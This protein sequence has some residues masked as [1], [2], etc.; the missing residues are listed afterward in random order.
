MAKSIDVT[1]EKRRKLDELNAAVG[2]GEDLCKSHENPVDYEDEDAGASFT[3]TKT[4]TAGPDQTMR[5]PDCDGSTLV[6]LFYFKK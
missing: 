2:G 1:P 4:F 3:A 5:D 6:S